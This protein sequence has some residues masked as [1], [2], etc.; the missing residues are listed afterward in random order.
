LLGSPRGGIE[1]LL[2]KHT[3]TTQAFD[4]ITS[5]INIFD[6]ASHGPIRCWA[7]NECA[8]IAGLVS[9]LEK[10][11]ATRLLVSG[12][13]L[14]FLSLGLTQGLVVG[15]FRNEVGDIGAKCLRYQ[16]VRN[17]AVLDRIMQQG[18]NYEVRILLFGR[19]CNERGDFQ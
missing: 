3:G 10:L 1:L 5:P 9:K 14:E 19:L 17:L 12:L 4:D 7:Q 6:P 15:Y 2:E 18:S 11:C 13:G 8:Q 16:L